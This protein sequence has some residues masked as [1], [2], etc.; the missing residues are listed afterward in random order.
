MQMASS[1]KR[2]CRRWRSA[3]EYTATVLMPRSLQ[4]QMTRTAISP[5]LAIRIFS[6][7]SARTNREQGLAVLHSAAVLH[8]LGHNGAGYFR[9]D[10]VHQLHRFDYAQHLPRLD[11]IT[12]L[13]EWWITRLRTFVESADDRA[14]DD[15]FVGGGRRGG[16]AR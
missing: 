6:N 12:H 2:T 1:A 9:L 8:Q 13:D 11:G 3:S 5:R 15:H 14:L 10:F 4:A 16:H 7:M